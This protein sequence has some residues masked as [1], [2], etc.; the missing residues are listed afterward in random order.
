MKADSNAESNA[1]QQQKQ[2]TATPST[3]QN[4]SQPAAENAFSAAQDHNTQEDKDHRGEQSADAQGGY[5][6]HQGY[7]QGNGQHDYGDGPGNEQ[8]EQAGGQGGQGGEGQSGSTAIKEDGYVILST[9][10]LSHFFPM[11]IGHFTGEQGGNNLGGLN[12]YHSLC[13]LQQENNGEGEHDL[14][15]RRKIWWR[16]RNSS[17]RSLSIGLYKSRVE[18]YR[19]QNGGWWDVRS[20]EVDIKSHPKPVMM[21][22]TSYR[23]NLYCMSIS[24]LYSFDTLVCTIFDTKNWIR[25]LSH[26]KMPYREH[27]GTPPLW[28]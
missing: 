4:D 22:T 13:I 12:T 8:K 3:V 5:D 16:A 25:L 1:Q 21:D 20:Q 26:R 27:I 11:Y 15:L 9:A 18:G 10:F 17:W 6:D 2:Q 23:R 28:N 14:E 19:R 7:D 24:Y